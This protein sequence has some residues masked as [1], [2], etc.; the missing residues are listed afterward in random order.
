MVGQHCAIL[1]CSVAVSGLASITYCVWVCVSVCVCV[2]TEAQQTRQMSMVRNCYHAC[3]RTHA[4]TRD[5]VQSCCMV[6][7]LM[8]SIHIYIYYIYINSS[9]LKIIGFIFWI[10]IP[11]T[12]LHT[13]RLEAKHKT[14]A[15]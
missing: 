8:H 10:L 2:C 1:Q 14:N 4:R 5:I 7:I 13:K 15:T 6:I 9:I 12:A 11:S 3:T